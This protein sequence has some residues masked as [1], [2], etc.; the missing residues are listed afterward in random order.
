MHFLSAEDRSE[1]LACVRR[2]REAHG[3]ARR[4]NAL[5]LLDAGMSCAQVAQVLFVDDDTVRGW[6]KQYLSDGWE[7]V[8]LDGWRGGASRLTAA[9]EAALAEWLEA[10]ICRSTREVRAYILRIFRVQYAHSG[11][12][13]L[14]RR[15][16]FE[17]RKPRVALRPA[18]P[19]LQAA[20]IANYERLMTGLPDDE[21]VY[22]ADAVHPEYQARPGYGWMRKG[23]TPTLQQV[24]TRGR[25]NIHGALNLETFDM[26]F[27]EPLR[28]DGESAVRLLAKIEARNPSKRRIHVIWDNASYHKGADVRAFLARPDCRIRLIALP[29]RCPHLNPIE[30]LWAVMHQHVTNNRTYPDQTRFAQAILHFFRK[31]VPKH[32]PSFR[33]RVTDNFHII[34]P[35]K[36]RILE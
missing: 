29:R 27:V 6:H 25:V 24:E 7:A 26:P 32:W 2:Q 36:S 10:R 12:L 13:K 23:A 1:L 14:L 3:I 11:C 22:F 28:V 34:D 20:F 17:Y 15:L 33:D 16:G 18:D 9:Q 8:A 19:A 5:L 4:A 30:R 21:A 35:Q 31:T